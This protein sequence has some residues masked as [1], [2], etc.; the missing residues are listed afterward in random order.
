VARNVIQGTDQQVRDLLAELASGPGSTPGL[1]DTQEWMQEGNH[2]V[3]SFRRTHSHA[4][5]LEIAAKLGIRGY[6]TM[7]EKEL[8]AEIYRLAPELWEE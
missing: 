4:K 3:Y 7:P 1:K 2:P 5:C 6:T 8:V